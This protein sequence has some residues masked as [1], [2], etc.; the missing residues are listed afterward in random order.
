MI[1]FM[2][3]ITSKPRNPISSTRSSR[4]CSGGPTSE[5]AV[6]LGTLRVF[7]VPT[8]M[9][10]IWAYGVRISEIVANTISQSFRMK[11]AIQQHSE[12]MRCMQGTSHP[13]R[14]GLLHQDSIRCRQR[15][16]T[17]LVVWLT[18]ITNQPSRQD[19]LFSQCIY[20]MKLWVFSPRTSLFGS[21][22]D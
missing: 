4:R 15:S 16:P 7:K 10:C 14:T 5:A 11:T 6:D 1:I 3:H 17:S 21:S 22:S 12:T 19:S 8:S 2:P 20:I 9:Y 13:C 18:H